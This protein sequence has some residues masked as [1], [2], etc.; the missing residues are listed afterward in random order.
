MIH[1]SYRLLSRLLRSMTQAVIRKGKC[2]YLTS[3]ENGLSNGHGFNSWFKFPFSSLPFFFKRYFH[4]FHRLVIRPRNNFF[5]RKTMLSCV[6]FTV[7]YNGHFTFCVP[8]SKS[9]EFFKNCSDQQKVNLFKKW[10]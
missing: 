9:R 7:E 3:L 2:Q 6:Y 10:V 5:H 4:D 1:L 8:G